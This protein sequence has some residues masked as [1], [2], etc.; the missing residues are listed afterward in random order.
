V[1]SD[2]EADLAPGAR[3]GGRYQVEAALGRGG[4]GA[5]YRAIDTVE[6]RPVAL[7]LLHQRVFAEQ[8]A[9]RTKPPG[10]RA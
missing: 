3:V 10:R 6:A 9:L 8:R 1:S 4:M 7:K 2:G 5:V